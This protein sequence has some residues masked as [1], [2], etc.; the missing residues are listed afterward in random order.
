MDVVLR[1]EPE[2]HYLSRCIRSY[3]AWRFI[4]HSLP[5]N[6]QVLSFSHGDNYYGERQRVPFYAPSLQSVVYAPIG[7][8]NWAVERLRQL[9]ITHILFDRR[10]LD[11]FSRTAAIANPTFVQNRYRLEYEDEN[12]ILYRL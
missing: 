9:G 11:E 10:S 4:N 6:A 12:F 3:S 8:E 7:Q 5:L 1:G 2:E